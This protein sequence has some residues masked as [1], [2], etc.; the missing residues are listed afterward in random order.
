MLKIGQIERVEITGYSSEGMGVCRIEGCAVFVPNAIRGELCDVKVTH[1]SRNSAHGK[2]ERILIRSPHRISRACPEAKLCGGCQLHHMD[3]AEELNFKAQKVTDA[4]RRLGGVK[5]LPPGGKVPPQGADEGTSDDWTVPITGADGSGMQ[6]AKCKL[7]N[8]GS[9]IRDQRSGAVARAICPLDEATGTSAYS[10]ES[11]VGSRCTSRTAA[12][13]ATSDAFGPLG[14]QATGETTDPAVGS[15][16]LIAPVIAADNDAAA[17]AAEASGDASLRCAAVPEAVYAYRNKAQYPIGLKNGKPIAGFYKNRTHEVVPIKRCAIL[18]ELFDRVKDVVMRWAEEDRV[19]VYDETTGEGLLR[20]IYVRKGSVS[21]QLMVCIVANGDRLPRENRLVHA[22]CREIPGLASVILSVNTKPTNV[23]LGSEFRTLWG[24]DW[25]EDELCG[26]TFRLSPRSFYQVNHDQAQRLYEKAV[27][28][29]DL[30]GTE[31]VL[32]LY[33]GTGTI[34]LA[35]S[36]KAG[37]AVGVEVVPEAIADAKENAARNGVSNVEFF[38]ADA[39]EA[40]KRF[41]AK[42]FPLGG[43]CHGEAVTDE[44]ASRQLSVSEDAAVGADAHIGPACP[45][46]AAGSGQ[47]AAGDDGCEATGNRHQA[48]DPPVETNIACPFSPASLLAQDEA[49]G[50]GQQAAGDDGCEAAGNRKQETRNEMNCPLSPVTCHFPPPEVIVVDPPRKGLAPEV[51]DAMVQ[52]APD[53]IV[54]VSCDPATLARDVKLLTAQGYTLTQAEAF[55]LFPRTF[56]VETVVQL[57]RKN[58]DMTVHVTLNLEDADLTASEAKATYDQIKAYVLETFGLRVTSLQIAQT[59][60]KLGLP[61][62]EHYNLSQKENQV[63]PNCPPE[64]ES[65]IRE[66]LH[67][68]QMM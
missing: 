61:T 2:I 7:Q 51:I 57:V 12:P 28:L 43:R 16:P 23:V 29:A 22:L 64:K 19:P 17:P 45:D 44:G 66:A 59:K 10:A 62:G 32:D 65:A 14:Q 8:E 21:G 39:G 30:H 46:E 50:S 60:R 27:D 5:G 67:H 1:V 20:H 6:N 54:Y 56:H 35:L 40:A 31:T 36:R 34:T 48:S 47:Q 24:Q 33:C 63:I 41:A 49:A 53:R 55:D 25:I 15:D 37:R 42:A 52:M 26:F 38:C 9:G 18:P 3:Y 68:F 58:P 4:L 13:G 11:P